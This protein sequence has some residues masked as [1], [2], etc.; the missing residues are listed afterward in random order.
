MATNSLHG[1]IIKLVITLSYNPRGTCHYRFLSGKLKPA[2]TN[3][4]QGWAV[5]SVVRV[6]ADYGGTSS[7]EVCVTA[8]KTLGTINVMNNKGG[9]RYPR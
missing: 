4:S 9:V 8:D 5:T 2:V 7:G 1:A 3:P 6:V